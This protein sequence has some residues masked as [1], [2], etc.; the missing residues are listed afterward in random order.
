MRNVGVE[1]IELKVP[2]ASKAVGKSLQDLGLPDDAVVALL[3]RTGKSQVPHAALVL[4]RDDELVIVTSLRSEENVR[5]I[6]MGKSG[7]P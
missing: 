2:G 4:A 5:E 6:I 1:I 7:Q 3:I